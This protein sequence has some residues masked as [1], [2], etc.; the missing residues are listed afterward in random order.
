M[1][2]KA[3]AHLQSAVS[4]TN[5]DYGE[6][7]TPRQTAHRPSSAQHS[8]FEEIAHGRKCPLNFTQ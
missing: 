8:T 2:G 5:F 4:S 1:T 3:D 7:Q 6:M